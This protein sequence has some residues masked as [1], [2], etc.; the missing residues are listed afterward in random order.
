MCAC[1]IL[2]LCVLY[3]QFFGLNIAGIMTNTQKITSHETD[4]G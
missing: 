3:V 4:E 1:A 2:L